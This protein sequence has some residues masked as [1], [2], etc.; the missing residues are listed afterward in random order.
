MATMTSHS[1][2]EYS[3][4]CDWQ[5]IAA[6]QQAIRANDLD[7]LWGVGSGRGR[8]ALFGRPT[9]FDGRRVV[10]FGMS[11]RTR[12]PFESRLGQTQIKTAKLRGDFASL[13]D[14]DPRT[15]QASQWGLQG[16]ALYHYLTVPYEVTGQLFDQTRNPSND[17]PHILVDEESGAKIILQGHH[18]TAAALLS[19]RFV[20]ARLVRGTLKEEYISDSRHTTALGRRM[21]L[22]T[23]PDRKASSRCVARGG[24]RR[25][26]GR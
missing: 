8:A 13:A 17:W 19:G 11:P 15:V 9:R 24:N 23:P 12:I 26:S 2:G 25:R 16:A 18:R 6:L 1:N 10:S 7:A 3:I 14:V 20:R 4:D 21:P 5:E 22:N